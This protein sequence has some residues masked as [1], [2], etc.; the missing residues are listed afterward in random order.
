LEVEMTLLSPHAT[1]AVVDA[2]ELSALKSA[3]A[4]VND[5][6]IPPRILV[7]EEV[8]TLPSEVVDAVQDL[9]TRFAN[10][11]SVVIGSARTLL[12]TSQVADLLGVSRSFVVHLIDDGQLDY[13]FRGT[14]RRV[15]LTE[16]VR[17]LE[18]S[19]RERRAKLDAIA[20]VTAETGGYDGDP[21]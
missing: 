3:A 1:E 10:G 17:Y 4:R 12:T 2:S 9:L 20:E 11:D 6:V 7:G 16:T 19:K 14:H 13:E 18:E 5:S 21:F 8:I 15:S